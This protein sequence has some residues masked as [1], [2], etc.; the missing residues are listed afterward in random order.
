M[1]KRRSFSGLLNNN[2]FVGYT[3]IMPWIIGFLFFMVI[4]LAISIFMSFRDYSMIGDI[5]KHS[6]FVGWKNYIWLFLKDEKFY[7]S[8][9]VTFFYVLT[10][11]PLSKSALF[12]VAIFSFYWR[13]ND[14]TQALIYL[15]STGLFTVTVALQNFADPTSVSNWGAMFAMSVLSIVPVFLVFFFLQK[16][17]TEGISTAGL[18]G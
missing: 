3:F 11:V 15:N 9:R 14:F 16:N 7:E 2:H 13:W 8:M 17:I 6:K 18:K 10:A 5:F 12:T 1:I 4:P